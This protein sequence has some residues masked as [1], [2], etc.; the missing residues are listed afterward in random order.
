MATLVLLPVSAP[1]QHTSWNL[2]TNAAR[3][4]RRV[5]Y[6]KQMCL[7]RHI[8]R[9]TC[10]ITSDD[11]VPEIVDETYPTVSREREHCEE[12]LIE[13]N[14]GWRG[15]GDLTLTQLTSL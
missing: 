15:N 5:K 2:A 4:C 12:V 13:S 9:T 8:L 6:K 11:C 10:F 1:I 7:S 14:G 3:W